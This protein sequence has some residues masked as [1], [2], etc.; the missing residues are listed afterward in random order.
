MRKNTFNNVMDL[1]IL[2]IS[3]NP[4]IHLDKDMFVGLAG[5]KL[6]AVFMKCAALAKE[7][8]DVQ[9]RSLGMHLVLNI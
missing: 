6:S 5:R 9:Q 7:T 4:L 3:H 8:L 1:T 2:N